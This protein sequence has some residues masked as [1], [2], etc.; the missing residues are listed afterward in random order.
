MDRQA[1]RMVEFL[2]QDDLAAEYVRVGGAG[3]C[4]VPHG[5]EVRQHQ[6]LPDTGS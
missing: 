2:L 6:S 1:Q 5:E 4:D 3:T